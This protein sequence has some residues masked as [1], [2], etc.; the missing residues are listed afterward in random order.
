[1]A[2]SYY[3][4]TINL[5]KEIVDDHKVSIPEI[6]DLI[7]NGENNAKITIEWLRSVY[8]E[9]PNDPGIKRMDA[10]YRVLRKKKQKMDRQK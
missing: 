10:L 3:D 4:K 1:M 8:R 6:F 2:E 9:I 5:Y 7:E